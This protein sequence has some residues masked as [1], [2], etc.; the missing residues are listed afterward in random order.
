MVEVIW[1][2]VASIPQSPDAYTSSAIQ[3]SVNNILKTKPGERLFNPMFGCDLDS[4]LFE[5]IDEFTTLL[6]KQELLKCISR[7]DPRIRVSNATKVIAH[8][9]Q[10]EYQ[11]TL[12]LECYGMEDD[13]ILNFFLNKLEQ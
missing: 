3:E 1:K 7:W 4:L 13:V 2:D 11:V 9:D 6:I 12:V 5:P 8:E 10:L